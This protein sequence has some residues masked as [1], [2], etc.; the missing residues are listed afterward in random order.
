VSR[1]PIDIN[2]PDL[3]GRLALVTGASDG[4]GL[5]LAERL[6]RAGA[7]LLLPVRS[8]AKGAAAADRIR[9]AA[10]A[11]A[12]TVRTLDL[13]SLASIAALA[14][15]LLGDG[16]PIE[17]LVNN[18]GI[19]TPPSRLESEDGFE[20]QFA[21]N[22]LGHFALTGRLLPLLRAGRAR[23]TTQSSIAANRHGL[24][25]DD[26]QWEKSYDK[27]RAYSSSKI[28]NGLF[29]LQLDRLSREYGWGISSNVAHPGISATNLLASH[30]EMG[31]HGDTFSVRLI[32]RL[33]AT[34]I[35]VAQT[36]A[37][38]VLPALYAAT[39]PDARGGRFYGPGGPMQLSG[40]PKEQEPYKPIAGA[41]DAERL[42]AVSEQLTQVH[43]D[44]LPEGARRSPARPA[45]GPS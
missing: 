22:H 36:A 2:P 29:G 32:R 24:H 20:L 31:R 30:P 5:A 41:Q 12:I 1:P 21:T 4:L 39:S 14:D 7:D 38:G 13:A 43:W 42:W 23:V 26:L 45:A 17:I 44:S 6:A 3:T 9:A 40:A 27:N 16:R 37:E 19:M 35:P 10:P 25:W 8:Q 33:A 15:E 28:A 34:R 18:A 11:A